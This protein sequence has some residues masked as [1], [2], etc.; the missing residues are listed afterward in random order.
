MTLG[1]A[2]NAEAGPSKTQARS[3]QAQQKK[4]A[5][6][7]AG[8]AVDDDGMHSE[9]EEQER[10]EA[11]GKGRAKG[12]KAFE[13]RELVAR[14]FAGDNVI[15]EFAEA[16]RRDIQEDAPKEVDTTL[17]GWVSPCTLPSEFLW[18]IMRLLGLLGWHRRKEGATKAV[19][20][21]E[22]CRRGPDDT[23]RLQEGARHHLGE[24][25][26]EGEQVSCQRPAVPVHEQSA[27]RA[28]HGHADRHRVEHS[29]RLPA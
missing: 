6:L 5:R 3:Q 26:Q 16:K 19:P 15:Q 9:I 23:R 27:V 22:N 18:L 12:V 14:A 20:H 7:Q 2:A 11:R 4:A 24:A 17:P 28:E 25:R 13:Q 10:L 1:G 8:E 29:C 21:Q